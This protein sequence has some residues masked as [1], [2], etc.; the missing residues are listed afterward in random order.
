MSKRDAQSEVAICL[1]KWHCYPHENKIFF[2]K[3][4]PIPGDTS[5]LLHIERCKEGI[6]GNDC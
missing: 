6:L 2:N 1:L 4:R 3:F 5:A